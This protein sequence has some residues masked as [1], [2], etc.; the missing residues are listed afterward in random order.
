[1]IATRSI[2]GLTLTELGLGGA[3]LGH[4]YHEI[5]DDDAAAIVERAWDAGVRHFD[6]APHYG[7]GLSERRLGA[8]LR[9]PAR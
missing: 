9:G 2:R 1:M 8:L 6:T 5:S 4:L 7:L 3:Q